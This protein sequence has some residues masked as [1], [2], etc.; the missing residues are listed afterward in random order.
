MLGP[1]SWGWHSQSWLLQ[2]A[3][4]SQQSTERAGQLSAAVW[5]VDQPLTGRIA[6][7]SGTGP[8][9]LSSTCPNSRDSS[10]KRVG[11]LAA[12]SLLGRSYRHLAEQRID[13]WSMPVW[14]FGRALARHGLDSIALSCHCLSSFWV[15]G[16]PLEWTQRIWAKAAL[17]EHWFCAQSKCQIH[18]SSW[19]RSGMS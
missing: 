19:S 17:R 16:P 1:L 5:P 2:W 14:K 10:G 15:F 9:W 8:R 12:I 11:L 4:R 6:V 18:C 13:T 7:F 3:S